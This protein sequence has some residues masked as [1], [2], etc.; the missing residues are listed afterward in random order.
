MVRWTKS[1]DDHDS[2]SEL[3]YTIAWTY[4]G[5]SHS[6]QVIGGSAFLIEGI[7]ANHVT[8]DFGVKAKDLN[9]AESA[10][11]TADIKTPTEANILYLGSNN[12]T[13]GAKHLV[14]FDIDSDDLTNLSELA[15]LSFNQNNSGVLDFKISL[16]EEWL[17]LIS[18]V[19]S[20]YVY[21]L[22]DINNHLFTKKFT[23]ENCTNGQVV[24][25]P[26]LPQPPHNQIYFYIMCDNNIGL[27]RIN[28]DNTFSTTS[29]EFHFGPDKKYMALD[30]NRLKL[31]VDT[32]GKLFQIDNNL[33]PNSVVQFTLGFEV[34]ALKMFKNYDDKLF[35]ASKA[36]DLYS[37]YVKPDTG[38]IVGS[39]G[40]T[41]KWDQISISQSSVP[42]F[43]GPLLMELSS[44]NVLRGNPMMII[45]NPESV[46]V[47]EYD[48]DQR[49]LKLAYSEKTHITGLTSNLFGDFWYLGMKKNM[50]SNA[51][52]LYLK[53]DSTGNPKFTIDK[54]GFSGTDK[55]DFSSLGAT[56]T[57]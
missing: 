9:G 36:G 42:P 26:L 30:N 53:Y 44:H 45:A 34:A 15:F 1:T 13:V 39:S 33:N 47:Y 22:P 11:S 7:P 38:T 12:P 35:I 51:Q 31:Y 23:T 14:R 28:S 6:A 16:N 17:V 48:H 57:E 4:Q 49:V 5:N 37:I 21:N 40:G 18:A 8:I 54:T 25:S 46:Y 56:E 27:L 29:Q 19:N 50:G 43:S 32:G 3:K 41:P 10:E 2:Q 52:L 24:R 55:D 20:Y